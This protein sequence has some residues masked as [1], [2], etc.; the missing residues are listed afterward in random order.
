MPKQVSQGWSLLLAVCTSRNA[1][2]DEYSQWKIVNRAMIPAMPYAK[3]LA[4]FSW[5]FCFNTLSA[6]ATAF[7]LAEAEA[8]AAFD[9]AAEA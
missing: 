7:A 3:Y 1:E 2:Q 5:L 4:E 6:A 8:A 9:A